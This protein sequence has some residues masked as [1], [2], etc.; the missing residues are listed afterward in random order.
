MARCRLLKLLLAILASHKRAWA[1]AA[2]LECS[3]LEKQP[4]ELDLGKPRCCWGRN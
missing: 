2:R 3:K 1:S 4:V